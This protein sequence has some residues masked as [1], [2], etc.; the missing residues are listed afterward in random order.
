V[1]NRFT[2]WHSAQLS[3]LTPLLLLLMLLFDTAAAAV[4]VAGLPLQ[5]PTL[6]PLV[7]LTSRC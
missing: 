5:P 1:P 6:L 3:F 2:V 7:P 4:A